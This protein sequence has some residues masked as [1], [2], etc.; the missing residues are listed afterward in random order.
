M[1]DDSEI[2]ILKKW[3][4]GYICDVLL[5]GDLGVECWAGKREIMAGRTA[6]EVENL[7]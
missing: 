5:C 3:R 1:G 7:S 2:G 4:L 6:V